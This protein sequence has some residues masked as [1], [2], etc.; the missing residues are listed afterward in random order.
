MYMLRIFPKLAD[1]STGRPALEVATENLEDI[2]QWQKE[3]EDSR[4]KVESQQQDMLR[5][6]QFL[7]QQSRSKRIS[8]EMSN[9]VIYCRPVPFS[10]ESKFAAGNIGK[11]CS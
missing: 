10:F 7:K 3:I 4:N 2:L 9:L 5:Q 11:N 8:L 1:T 6:E